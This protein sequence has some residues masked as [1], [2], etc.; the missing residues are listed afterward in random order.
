VAS[1]S[2]RAQAPKTKP[3]TEPPPAAKP[4]VPP[5]AP[6]PGPTPAQ[7]DWLKARPNYVRI[8][9]YRGK[10]TSRGTLKTDGAFIPEQA[11]HPVMDGPGGFGVGVPVV[12]RRR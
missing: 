12:V 9:H 2:K 7:R 3:I 8:S 10:T 6:P 1:P 4:R 5:P 11:N